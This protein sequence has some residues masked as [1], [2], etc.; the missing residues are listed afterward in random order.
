MLTVAMWIAG[1]FLIGVV[2]LFVGVMF[3][4]VNSVGMPP[5]ECTAT[6]IFW[7][8]ALTIFMIMGINTPAK[9]IHRL[10]RDA[11]RKILKRY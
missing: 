2:V 5:G 10:A 3:N 6:I 8:I 9:F 1:Y 11:R 7:P 4:V